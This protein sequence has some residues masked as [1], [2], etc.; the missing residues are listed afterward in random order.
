MKF[1]DME[2]EVKSVASRIEDQG[3]TGPVIVVLPEESSD[4]YQSAYK[5]M[6]Q[7]LVPQVQ[8]NI[9]LVSL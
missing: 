6:L 9:K 3:L 2:S 8:V 7:K 4:E 5:D 1:V